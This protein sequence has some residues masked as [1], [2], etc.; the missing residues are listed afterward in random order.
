LEKK[1][2]ETL[3]EMYR[4]FNSIAY[5]TTREV[6]NEF[7][8]VTYDITKAYK[9]TAAKIIMEYGDKIAPLIESYG[10]LM[11]DVEVNDR[12]NSTCAV[13]CFNPNM[14]HRSNRYYILGFERTCFSKCGC[15]FKFE[16]N[17]KGQEMKQREF[18]KNKNEFDNFTNELENDA[19]ETVRPS[20][21]RFARA[22]E[23]LGNEFTKAVKD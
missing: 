10:D 6:E 15:Q 16:N 13:R 1:V 12:C 5:W 20:V 11:D 21:N 7:L 9:N 14:V 18:N 4:V 19:Y 23:N 17:T 22:V 2:E 8:N 3:K